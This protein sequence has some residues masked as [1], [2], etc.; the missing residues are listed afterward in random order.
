MILKEK[1]C[2]RL[3][4]E[5]RARYPYHKFVKTTP[6]PRATKNSRGELV[7]PPLLPLSLVDVGLGPDAVE[8]GSADMVCESECVLLYGWRE[9]Q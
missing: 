1:L 6:K 3:L 8:V 5:E 7:G 4:W 2:E 9:S